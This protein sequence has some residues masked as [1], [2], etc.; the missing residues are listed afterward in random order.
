DINPGLSR[1]EC[2]QKVEDFM[3]G[4]SEELEITQE[5][6]ET[7]EVKVQ[8]LEAQCGSGEVV[9]SSGNTVTPGCQTWFDGCNT[10]KVTEPGTPMACTKK[11]CAAKGEAK[12]MDATTE[13][14]TEGTMN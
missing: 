5:K 10:C 4:K 2:E 1:P 13:A 11:A 12:C 7:T 9:D 6:L 8:E 14:T 3:G